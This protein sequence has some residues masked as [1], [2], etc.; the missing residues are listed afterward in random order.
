MGR[1]SRVCGIGL[2][3]TGYLGPVQPQWLVVLDFCLCFSRL[4]GFVGFTEP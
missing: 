3:V 1:D 2:V 4:C